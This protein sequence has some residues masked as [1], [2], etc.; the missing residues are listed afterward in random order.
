MK[1]KKM[2]V[3]LLLAITITLFTKLN[4][5]ASD[6]YVKTSDYFSDTNDYECCSNDLYVYIESNIEIPNNYNVSGN[7][8]ELLNENITLIKRNISLDNVKGYKT[9]ASSSLIKDKVVIS[10]FIIKIESNSNIKYEPSS[11]FTVKILLPNEAREHSY[12][13]VISIEDGTNTIKVHKT[14]RIG[15]WI[16]FETD[17]FES[18]Y[19]MADQLVN[20]NEKEV[21][22]TPFIIVTFILIILALII[23]AWISSLIKRLKLMSTT[24]PILLVIT[25][26]GGLYILII[27]LIV[28]SLQILYLLYLFFKFRK[29]G[30]KKT[31]EE[32]IKIKIIK[33]ERPLKP[34]GIIINKTK[35]FRNYY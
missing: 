2:I 1:L 8:E 31:I 28:L 11:N 22:L 23:I 20:L 25:P 32:N 13:D 33:V 10:N 34:R 17:N 7:I 6:T 24:I 9:N 19:L 3:I 5:S 14:K 26:F 16:T 21:N 29:L 35:Y 4:V 18:F 27:M 30:S 15:N 12:I